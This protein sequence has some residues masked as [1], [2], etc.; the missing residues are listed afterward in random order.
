MTVEQ[1]IKGYIVREI[2]RNGD[3]TSLAFDYPL[4]EER[5]LDSMD[6]QRLIAFVE[7]HFGVAVPD[8]CL[9]PENFADI[10]AIAK[11]VASLQQTV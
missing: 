8:E 7:T 9:L 6:L 11:M 2:M 5:I 3:D 10:R 4:I 1:A